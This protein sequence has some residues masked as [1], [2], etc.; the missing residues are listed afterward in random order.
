MA[1]DRNR[2]ALERMTP[3]QRAAVERIKAR[4]RSP[5]HGAE[6]EQ[7]AHEIEAANARLTVDEPLGD[8]LA[9]FKL[10][11]E[12][13]G[14]SLADVHE[15]SKLDPATVSKLENGHLPNPTYTTL[16]AYA[17]ALGLRIGFTLEPAD[18]S[19]KA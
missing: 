3:E 9:R 1:R 5:E 2:E 7:A 16:R 14:L 4:N 8:L 13:L 15:R 18:V 11:R 12:R 19:A 6:L 17:R 10:E